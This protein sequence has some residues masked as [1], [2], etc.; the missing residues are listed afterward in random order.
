[1]HARLIDQATMLARLGTP[2]HARMRRTMPVSMST[3]FSSVSCR[4]SCSRPFSMPKASV[5]CPGS[6]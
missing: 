4:C 5:G 2:M 1:M 3:G 6:E